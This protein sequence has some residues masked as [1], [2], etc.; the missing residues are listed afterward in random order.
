MNRQNKVLNVGGVYFCTKSGTL[1]RREEFAKIQA[2]NTENNLEPKYLQI[3]IPRAIT[4]EKKDR[5]VRTECNTSLK[6]HFNRN[7]SFNLGKWS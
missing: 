4:Q 6:H 5:K 7:N 3:V 1:Y 2:E